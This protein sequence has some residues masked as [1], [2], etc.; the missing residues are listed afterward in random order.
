MVFSAIFPRIKPKKPYLCLIE[1]HNNYRYMDKRIDLPTW[2]DSL[3]FEQL[4]A[5][6]ER[7]P[8]DVQYNPDKGADFVKIYLGTY[9]PRSYAEAYCIIGQLLE[10]PAYHASLIELEEISVLDL[11]CG[12]GGEIFG[13]ICILQEKLPNLKRINIDAFDANIHAVR[14]LAKLS[15]EIPHIDEINVEV[16]LNPQALN[17]YGEQNLDDIIHFVDKKYHFILSFKAL[18]EFIQSK[19]FPDENVYTKIA[20][21]FLPLI[22]GNGALVM[23]DLTHKGDS[24]TEF[25]PRIMN[26][27]IN[28]LLRNINGYRTIFPYPCFFHEDRCGGCYMQDLIQVNHSGAV[29]DRSKIAYR[30]ICHTDFANHIME[31]VSRRKCQ[32]NYPSSWVDKALP[33]NQS[34]YHQN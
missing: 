33:Y 11:C 25:Y 27:G 26:H 24:E 7:R 21:H 23:T 30:V 19:T 15:G 1:F 28:S 3:I 9:F 17:I 22:T 20:G 4:G 2:L 13:L 31:G 18:N 16:N 14:K 29:S 5:R 34:S 12:T 10:N 6:Y 8:E 32:I